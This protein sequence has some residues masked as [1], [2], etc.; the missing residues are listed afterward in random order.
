MKH[1]ALFESEFSIGFNI[2]PL[3]EKHKVIPIYK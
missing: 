3:I 2:F 1:G